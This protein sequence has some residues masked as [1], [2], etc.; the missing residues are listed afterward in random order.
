MHEPAFR[1]ILSTNGRPVMYGWWRKRS[2]ADR[3][4]T[5]WIGE[6]STIADARVV[7]EEQAA[8][9]TW[10]QVRVWPDEATPEV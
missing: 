8:D 6:Y 7:L 3:K 9:G 1:V 5:S 4:F 10:K 2:V